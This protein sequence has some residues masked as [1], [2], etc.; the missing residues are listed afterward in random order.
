M[1]RTAEFLAGLA[2]LAALS[3]AGTA[4]VAAL[5]LPIPGPV[6]GLLVYTTL[7]SLGIFVRSTVAARWLSSLL[8]ALIVP[9]LVGIAAFSPVLAAGGWRLAV[10]LVAGCVVTGVVT[11]ATFQAT[12]R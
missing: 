1:R 5:G 4:L 12:N 7:L 3:T 10:A 9:P 2:L 11:A 6:L 8:G